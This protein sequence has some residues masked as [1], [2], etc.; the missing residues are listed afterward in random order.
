M[1]VGESIENAGKE[2][3]HETVDLIRSDACDLQ[4]FRGRFREEVE[5]TSLVRFV[6]LRRKPG[7]WHV[8]VTFFQI[9]KVPTHYLSGGGLWKIFDEFYSSGNLESCKFL[10]CKSQDTFIHCIGG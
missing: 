5:S 2:S 4:R 6:H 7:Y 9:A 1:R 10:L 8:S 3:R